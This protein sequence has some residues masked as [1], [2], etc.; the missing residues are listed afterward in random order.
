MGLSHL[1]PCVPGGICHHAPIDEHDLIMF[2]FPRR[3]LSSYKLKGQSCPE[4][5]LIRQVMT[6]VMPGCSLEARDCAADCHGILAACYRD[7]PDQHRDIQ[8][9]PLSCFA[10]LSRNEWKSL[11][12]G[13]SDVMGSCHSQNVPF[14]RRN[15]R[16]TLLQPPPS[17]GPQLGDTSTGWKGNARCFPKPSPH[18]DPGV[19]P[20]LLREPAAIQA[21]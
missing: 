7:C 6:Q 15:S 2:L 5:C 18:S 14:S 10:Q 12:D 17:A 19:P 20:G 1:C 8:P 9:S 16:Q 11:P 21:Q 3:T 13:S 4:I